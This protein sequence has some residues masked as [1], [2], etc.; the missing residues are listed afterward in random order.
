MIHNDIIQYAD[1]T[2]IMISFSSI[3]DLQLSLKNIG[4]KIVE[5]MDAHNLIINAEKNRG[6]YFWE[7]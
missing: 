2:T 4:N 6:Y 3:D 5:Y 7:K 1:D